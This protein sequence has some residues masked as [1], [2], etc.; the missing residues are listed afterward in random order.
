MTTSSGAA[1]AYAAWK[2]AEWMIGL[3]AIDGSMD[4]TYDTITKRYTIARLNRDP[5]PSLE[6][7]YYRQGIFQYALPGGWRQETTAGP[8]AGLAPSAPRDTLP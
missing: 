8:Y 4:I 6:V 5:Y 3:D 2:A 1:V 7:D